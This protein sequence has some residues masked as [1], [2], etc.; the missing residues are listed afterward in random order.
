[1]SDAGVADPI[2]V[3]SEDPFLVLALESVVASPVHFVSDQNLSQSSHWPHDEA[4]TVV[5]DVPADQRSAV[6]K[7]VRH[8]HQGRLILVL[9]PGEKVQDLPHDPARLTVARPYLTGDLAALLAAPLGE[10]PGRAVQAGE[11]A[12]RS[13]A[14]VK[15]GTPGRRPA[16]VRAPIRTPW[17]PGT[18]GD[19]RSLRGLLAA[20]LLVAVAV[21]G[22]VVWFVGGLLTAAH[23]MELAAQAVRADLDQVNGALLAGNTAEAE[24]AVEAASTDLR[25]AQVV[26][27]RSAVRLAGHLPVFAQ[28]VDDLDRL[29]SAAQQVVRAADRAVTV[30]SQLASESPTMLRDRRFDLQLLAQARGQVNAL[31]GDITTARQELLAVRGTSLEP[32]VE[33]TK[34]ASLRQLEA[35]EGR[36]RPVV[37]TLNLLPSVLGSDRRRTYLVVLVNP[38]ELRPSGGI[39]AAVLRVIAHRGIITLENDMGATNRLRRSRARWKAVPDDPWQDESSPVDFFKANSSPHFPTAGEELLRAYQAKTKRRAD[40]VICVDPM[41]ARAVLNV[42]GSV[43]VPGYEQVTAGNVARL[44]MHDAFKRWPDATVRNRYNQALI[45]ALLRQFL[46][47]RLLLAKVKAL[48]SE[49]SQRHIQ[50]Y[51]RDP[52]LQEAIAEGGLDGGLAS[53]DHDYVGVYTQNTNA[54]RVDYFQTRS[55]RQE[56]QLLTDGSALVT[57]TIRVSNPASA[58]GSGTVRAGS[59]SRY[60]MPIVAAYLPPT[61]TLV[62]VYVDGRL[63]NR[64]VESEEA[65]RQF[66]RVPVTLEPGGSATIGVVYRVRTGAQPTID[67]LRYEF[68][69]DPQPMSRPPRLE[70]EVTAPTGMTVRAGGDWRV[71]GRQE[72]TLTV[73]LLAGRSSASLDLHRE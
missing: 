17:W 4:C 51:S 20:A 70:I 35:L 6:Y 9:D 5:V 2:V 33:R 23:D 52:H 37:R 44:T 22:F 40:G 72:A 71:R 21:L 48:V 46:D 54:S 24:R 14:G 69:A 13:G 28:L 67:G 19:W 59:R 10:Q 30:Y 42:T 53:A 66:V 32:R 11:G 49:T 7:A 15:A 29:I 47:G 38:A 25:S 61:A 55:I 63:S 62:S 1:M 27:S 73:V 64:G 12:P 31:Y 39:P 57:R 60:S 41:A 65:G 50:I 58:G 26:A 3:L 8:H 18:I 56:V 16:L 36:A 43:A 45:N 34:A 68:V